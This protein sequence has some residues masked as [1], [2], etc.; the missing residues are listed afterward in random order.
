MSQ[1]TRI[2]IAVGTLIVIILVVL[3][4]DALRRTAIDESDLPAGSVPIYVDGRLVGGF[5]PDDQAQLQQVEF[6]DAEEGKEQQ[7][8]LLRDVLSLHID[9][10][11]L[12]AETSI[13]VSSSSRDKQVTLTWAEVRDPEKWVMFDLSG[14]GTL[15]LVSVLERLDTRDE[16][17]QDVDKIEV[18]RP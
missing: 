6:T 14:R 7:G 3:G 4:V 17:I 10:D 9:A 15:K 12:A 16:W 13:T 18:R 5:A 1:R 2:L 11:E 8:W